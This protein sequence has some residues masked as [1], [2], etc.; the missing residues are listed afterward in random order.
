MS[1]FELNVDRLQTPHRPIR[2][3]GLLS[4]TSGNLG[5]AAMQVAMIANLRKRIAGVEIL[6]IT[7]NP[8][9]THRR[10]GIEAFP[11]AGVSRANYTLCNPDS[12]K[13]AQQH[14]PKLD[15][16][17]QWLKKIPMLRSVV[18]AIRTCGMELAHITAAAR[19]VR[20]LDRIIIPGGGTLDD[21]WGGPWGQPWAIFKW[22]VLSRVYG[23]PFLFVS[24]GKSSLERPLSR[25]FARTALRLAAYRSYR[26]KDSKIA[27]QF[28]IDASKDPVY[29]DLAFSYPCPTVQ[30]S[31][32]IGSQDGRLVVG[33]SPF[34]YCDPRAWPRKDERRYAAYVSQLAEMVKWLIKEHHR[35]L[36]F[37]TDSPDTATVED[38][39]TM[40]PGNAIDADAIQILPSSTEQSPDSLLK[41]ISRA[42]LTIASRLHGVILSHL[43]ATPVLALSF[44]P[45]VDAHMNAVG[46]R[47][48]CLD[49]DHLQF[50][51]FIERFNALR[52]SRER[53]AAH[54]RFAALAFRQQ[55]DIQY[56]RIL[57]A[58][59]A[60]SVTSDYHYQTDA[61]PLSELGGSRTR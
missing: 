9:E 43:N 59:P 48:Y 32:G 24:I 44:D 34:A 2:R 13:T 52:I 57:G 16:V 1:S 46:Q 60:S 28:L 58:S 33:V 14:T 45:K 7:L 21:F 40:I 30:T 27:V 10:H 5:N 12:S 53:E 38:I 61:S 49:I 20:K 22:S 25:F 41:G 23:V 18:R 3:V 56:E 42:D 19:V 15:G 37:T 11:L 47:D 29:P 17:K 55:L 39:L 54:I 35:V 51:T 36:L 26:D 4:P 50:N 31:H 8:D 6:G